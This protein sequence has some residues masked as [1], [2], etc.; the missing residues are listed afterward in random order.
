MY[1]EPAQ[2][3]SEFETQI[4]HKRSVCL[5]QAGILEHHDQRIESVT[6]KQLFFADG[7]SLAVGLVINS[8]SQ[9]P[10]IRFMDRGV[11]APPFQIDGELRL[12]GFN[13]IWM[14]EFSG[15]NTKAFAFT[16]DLVALGASA[17]FNAWA[18][19]QAYPTSPFKKGHWFIQPYNM[20]GY[21]L[22]RL[23]RLIITGKAAWFI[24]RFVNLLAV[25]G[26]E[27]NLRIIFDW[28]LVLAFRADIAVLAQTPSEHLQRSHFKAGDE[29][30]RQGD[31]AR[32]AFV[33]DCGR[34]KVIQDG[35]TIKELGPGDYFGEI[36]P[37]HQNRRVETV[38]CLSDCELRLV[39]Q[40]DLKAL[41]QSGWL[42]SKAIRNLSDYG[43]DHESSTAPSGMK[44]LTYIS[45]VNAILPAEDVLE[46]GRI[47]SANNRKVDVTG[48]LIAAGAYFFQI[49]EG[50]EAIVDQLLE[51]IGRDPRH[52][53]ITVLSSEHDCEERLFSDWDMK[54]VA[55]T[56][57]TDLMLQAVGLML[58]NIAQ[59][60]H[61][62]GRYT[63]PM[64]LK[65]LTEGINPLTVP[66]RQIG[67][68][69][70]SGCMTDFAAL[71]D[72]FSVAELIDTFNQYLEIC[73][74]SFIEFG[75]QVAR[76]SSS[77]IIAHFA[78]DQTNS[79]IA[80]CKEADQRLQAMISSGSKLSVIR[81]GFGIT[82]GATIEG[83]IGSSIK[84]DYTVLGDAVD[85]TQHLA[86]YARD[87]R[88]LIALDH[89]V[90]DHADTSWN[91][92]D[93]GEIQISGSGKR[94]RIVTLNDSVELT[95]S[96]NR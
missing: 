42:M 30:F 6:A 55:I 47:S 46:I 75:G 88:K 64:L 51:K 57:S 61:I 82:A 86:A 74:A 85:E 59:S 87:H 49:L 78:P 25:P 58:Q 14:P 70:V 43:A 17:G 81:F 5:E 7:Q 52:T 37:M 50:E 66:V 83:N 38:R 60:Y 27:R 54:T 84:M 24:S 31:A 56:E 73:S 92:Y 95:G 48:V 23:G 13:N 32:Y 41:I 89:S 44:R 63:Q 35:H 77:G 20:A 10:A 11:M 76:Y 28:F 68:I 40:D 72:R 94:V 19:S 8:V 22:C 12:A 65:L 39:S 26:L 62:I 4:S 71:G 69:V 93:A 33:V 21:S 45:K 9:L 3:W 16:D 91:F 34:L 1:G 96:A 15:L 67:R 53:D 80:A 79:A 29:V 36:L 18:Y 90:L 2:T